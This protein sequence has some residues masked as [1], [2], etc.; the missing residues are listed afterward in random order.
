M[1]FKING[2]TIEAMGVKSDSR[3][4]QPGDIFIAYK[5]V[6]VDGHDYIPQAIKAGAVAVVCERTVRVKAYPPIVIVVSDG[7]ETWADLCAQQYNY[8]QKDLKFVGITGT[9]GKTTTSTFIY[10]VL[11]KAGYRVG[12]ISTVSAKYNNKDISTGLHTTSPDPDQLFKLLKEMVDDEVEYVVLEVTSHALV[13]ER[14]YGIHFEACAVTNVT[15]EHLDL[16]NTYSQLI[17][18]KARLFEMSDAI[19]VNPDA[20]GIQEIL[21]YVPEKIIQNK[22]LFKIYSKEIQNELMSKNFLRK[23]PG[24]YNVQNASLAFEIAK[25]LGVNSQKAI[26]AIL[27]TNPLKGRFQYIPNDKDLNIIVDFAHTENS[28][29]NVLTAVKNMKKDNEKLITVFGCAGE[30]DK[31]KRPKMG[32]VASELSDIVIVTS[33]DPRSEDTHIIVNEIVAGNNKFD[34]TKEVDRRKAIEKAIKLANK[35]DWILIL[36]KG[37]E[38]SMNINGIEVPWSDEK[39]TRECLASM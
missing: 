19:F 34:F 33:E 39:E 14:Y 26:D 11:K 1:Q 29:R 6:L 10:E 7:R 22:K 3:K 27:Q 23:F 21:K 20:Q 12:L 18:D 15:S 16:H 24:E 30:R 38:E 28:M 2:R 13:Q 4:V 17:K 31:Q 25:Y 8:P 37:H 32:K 35:G 5:G 36:G 9:D